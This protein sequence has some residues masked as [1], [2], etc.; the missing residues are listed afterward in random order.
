LCETVSLFPTGR[1]NLPIIGD[2]NEVIGRRNVVVFENYRTG[3]IAQQLFACLPINTVVIQR[4]AFGF[5]KPGLGAR[6]ICKRNLFKPP[7]V[8]AEQLAFTGKPQHAIHLLD[9]AP[10]RVVLYGC[11]VHEQEF[12]CHEENYHRRFRAGALLRKAFI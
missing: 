11:L 2:F 8:F 1:A 10:N 5:G 3:R 9:I 7:R 6:E 12:R 4:D